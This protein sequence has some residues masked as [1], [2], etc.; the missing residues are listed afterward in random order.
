[1]ILE[2][3]KTKL[4]SI[5]LLEK[6]INSMGNSSESFRYFNSRSISA[7]KNHLCTVLLMYNNEPI[8]YGHLDK[9]EDNI[10]FGIAVVQGFLGSGN[11]TVITQYLINRAIDFNL[12]EIKLSVDSNNLPAIKLYIKHGFI[13]NHEKNGVLFFSKKLIL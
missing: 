8:G 13:K 11:G 9:E 6:F 10:W 12:P 5:K 1:M 4:E 7:I 3:D 2:I